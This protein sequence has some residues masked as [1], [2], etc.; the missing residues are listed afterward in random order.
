MS[1]LYQKSHSILAHS[2]LVS[3]V[4]GLLKNHISAIFPKN[5][6][7][8]FYIRNSA[9]NINVADKNDDDRSTV[10][11]PSLSLYLDPSYQD[12][13]FNGEPN[14]IGRNFLRKNAYQYRNIYR[15]IFKDEENRIY[16]SS[17]EERTKLNFEVLIR[18]ESELQGYNCMQFLRSV[19]V[20]KP[21]FINNVLLES[22]L[23]YTVINDILQANDGKYNL[24]DV[25]GILEFQDYLRN[26]SSVYITFKK[27][28][29]SGNFFYFYRYNT[30]ILC[31]IT[32][33]PT[34]NINQNN[35]VVEDVHV[36]FNIEMEFNNHMHYITEHEK[37]I[38]DPESV[39]SVDDGYDSVVF[40]STILQPIQDKIDKFILSK[41]ITILT[42]ANTSIDTTNFENLLIHK[43]KTFIDYIVKVAKDSTLPEEV[44]N[45][46]LKIIIYED[47][48]ELPSSE[49]E[50]KWDTYEV[51][52]L[53]PKRNYVYGIAIYVNGINV[54]E[55][56][57]LNELPD[58]RY[59]QQP[60]N[61][62]MLDKTLTNVI[63]KMVKKE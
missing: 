36:K 15:N 25:N 20:K 24:E 47:S 9:F 55:F 48:E 54:T 59:G 49:Y 26:N 39:I 1:E 32:D 46:N 21:Y 34:I 56:S 11:F 57:K 33:I 18:L 16:V 22:P 12:P 30:N 2:V 37:L 10:K 52:L 40:N 35:K 50:V 31:K 7:R 38:I 19:G 61:G 29:G 3:N 41:V 4:F 58:T 28:N 6:F 23:P 60:S 51:N 14:H 63:L 5:Y 45:D 53:N 27:N 43:H 44:I 13:T 8:D 42:E 17:F 62:M